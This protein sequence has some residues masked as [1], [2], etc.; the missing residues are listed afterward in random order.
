MKVISSENGYHVGDIV[1]DVYYVRIWDVGL[2]YLK[3]DDTFELVPNGEKFTSERIY[4]ILPYDDKVLIGTRT[5]GFF[6][7][8]GVDFTPFKTEVDPYIKGELYLPGFA[9]ED[10]RYVFNTQGNGAYLMDHDGKLLQSYT[11]DNGPPDNSVN[12]VYVDSRG[13]LWMQHFNGISS[14]NL[15]SNLTLLDDTVGISTLVR[16][17]KRN[18]GVLYFATNNGVAYLD[19]TENMVKPI[20]GTFGQFTQF[21]KFRNRLYA[22]SN[23]MGLIELKDKGWEYVRE[24]VNY[25]FRANGMAHSKKDSSRV[26]MSHQQGTKSFYFNEEAGQF[27]EE[28]NTDKLNNMNGYFEKKDGTLWISN[29]V[30]GEVFKIIP[31]YID[32]RLDLD[33]SEYITFGEKEGLPNS[34]VGISGSEEK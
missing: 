9:L 7:Y 13:V 14:T 15:S 20:S 18:D 33:E 28:S 29:S 10:G 27:Q 26:Y 2:C 21:L 23:G 8:D 31:K 6:L 24:N 30:D 16:A 3:D 5:Q 32:G 34:G 4:S 11:K 19:E 12:Y 17:V 25:D 22:I 1:N